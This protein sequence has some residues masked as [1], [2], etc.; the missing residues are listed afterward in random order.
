MHHCGESYEL[1]RVPITIK[2]KK[3]IDEYGL[4]E[5]IHRFHEL[6]KTRAAK[7]DFSERQLNSL[8]YYYLNNQS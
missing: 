5:S 7:Y 2:V 1:P 3:L 6:R 8:G 4:T